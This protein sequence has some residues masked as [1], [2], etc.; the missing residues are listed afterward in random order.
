LRPGRGFEEEVDEGAALEAVATLSHLPAD[1]GGSLRQIEETE[2]LRPLQSFDGQE[3]PM[4]EVE[5][6]VIE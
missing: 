2:D 4:R 1:A 6:S 5:G 3:V